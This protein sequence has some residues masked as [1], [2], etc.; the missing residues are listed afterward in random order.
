MWRCDK[1]MSH[2]MLTGFSRPLSASA[3]LACIVLLAVSS[4]CGNHDSSTNPTKPVPLT[5]AAAGIGGASHTFAAAPAASGSPALAAD[6]IPVT[7][8]KALLVVRDVRFV[9]P[10]SMG[11][12]GE[13][14][15]GQADSIGMGEEEDD[16]EDAGQVRFRGPF[17][18][19]LL[20][21]EAARLDTMM[22]MPGD[23][24]RVQGHLQALHEGDP[25][26]AD[27]PALVGYTV[28]LE[29]TIDGEGGGSFS[30]LTRID[31]EFQI[32]GLFHVE[33][34]TP[35]TAFVTFDLS[36]W[37]VDRDG[38]FLDP[39]DETND[40]AIQSAIRHSIKVGM[41][42]DHDGEMDDDMHA[43]EGGR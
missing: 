9:L 1:A 39:R 15:G 30:Y 2:N 5:L 18:I 7:F 8:T 27:H 40:Q 16:S 4:G 26:A 37:L 23:Y 14:L 19:D 32:R 28:C 38:H 3:T 33:E 21:G 12:E 22:V 41:D 11:D 24:A 29:G 25:D 43:E 17:V 13:D 31:N 6:E 35:A 10:E 20:S 42:D 34:E 36:K